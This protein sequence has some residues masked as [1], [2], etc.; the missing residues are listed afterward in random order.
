[1]ETVIHSNGIL[2]S[3]YILALRPSPRLIARRAPRGEALPE[4]DGDLIRSLTGYLYSYAD[5]IYI[6]EH[7]GQIWGFVPN[8]FPSS[9]L[10]FAFKFNIES[11]VALRLLE[12]SR[13]GESFEISE[14]VVTPKAR[15]SK[16]IRE[17]AGGF[18]A[19]IEQIKKCFGETE[20][21]IDTLAQE[22]EEMSRLVGC[23]I[24]VSTSAEEAEDVQGAGGFDFLT[25][26][27]FVLTMMM[28]ARENGESRSLKISFEPLSQGISVAAEL[29]A[30]E[31]D[32]ADAIAFWDNACAERLMPFGAFFDN[33]ALKFVLQPYRR[34][35]SYLGLKQKTKW[36]FN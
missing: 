27:M 2:F 1:M 11:G 35:L 19:F 3:E 28:L 22:C 36:D 12:Q 24:T 17:R 4:F 6:A 16:R 5:K 33:G 7:D 13:Y 34:E 29:E 32:C 10:V 20:S 18:D 23:P 26:R 31:E 8:A 30:T 9:S 21:T 14:S 15:M 25:F